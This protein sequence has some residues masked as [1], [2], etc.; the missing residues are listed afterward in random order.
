MSHRRR[1]IGMMLELISL[2]VGLLLG[3]RL[4]VLALIPAMA[5]ALILIIAAG[6]AR[7]N[8][9]WW[10]VIV[11]AAA[12]TSLQIGYFAGLW[13]RHIP[14]A[15]RSTRRARLAQPQGPS[16]VQPRAEADC[17]LGI[18]VFC[19]GSTAPSGRPTT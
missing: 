8:A 1:F 6:G 15:A 10:T 4:K 3:W 5:I 17:I 18:A 14:T 19:R 7:G 13:L 2:V 9:G 16:R 11:A 12:V